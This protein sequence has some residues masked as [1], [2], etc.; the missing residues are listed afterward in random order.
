MLRALIS[1]SIVLIELLVFV[2]RSM[3]SVYLLTLRVWQVFRSRDFCTVDDWKK[4]MVVG[5][6]EMRLEVM[7]ADTIL[8][9][10]CVLN[11]ASP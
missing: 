5:S 10:I 6:L 2:S 9:W 8:R 11:Q 1:W 7:V 3:D 4:Y